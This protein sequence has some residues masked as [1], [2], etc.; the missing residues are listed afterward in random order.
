M[1]KQIAT[2][3]LINQQIA[4]KEILD[5]TP[6]QHVQVNVQDS[7]RQMIQYKRREQKGAQM[8]KKQIAATWLI[9]QQIAKKE[10]LDWT[11][12]QLVQVN[13]QDIKPQAV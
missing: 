7:R 5:W 6:K 8:M 10:I 9:N 12:K 2:A 13:V 4:K 1:K 3:W 11:P